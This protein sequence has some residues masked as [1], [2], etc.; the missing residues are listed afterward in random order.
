MRGLFGFLFNDKKPKTTGLLEFSNP[1]MALEITGRPKTL[2]SQVLN[3]VSKR[4]GRDVSKLNDFARVVSGVESSY[5]RNLRNPESTAKGIYQFTD[6]SFATAKNRLKNIL[7]GIPENILKAPTVLDLSPEDQRALF[8]AH[9]TEDKGSDARILKYLEGES[10]ENLYLANHYK[11]VP[12][13]ATLKR[14]Q[15]FFG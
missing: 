8:F 13:E 15:E 11:G 10:G 3:S 14:L 4:L 12:D 6:D 1:Q 2:S 5:G 9:L 7:G